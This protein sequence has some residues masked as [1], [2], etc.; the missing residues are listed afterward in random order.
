M[1]QATVTITTTARDAPAR[2]AADEL[3]ARLHLPRVE[4]GAAGDA[5]LALVW[6]GERL[7]L[8]EQAE[9]DRKGM[10]VDFTTL[11]VRRGSRNL[12][13]KQPL[14]RAI[15]R[16][17]RT[18]ADA[19][20]GLGHD[21]VLLACLGY[22]VIAIERSPVVAALLEDG[23]R[24]AANDQTLRRAIGGRIRLVVGDARQVL[25]TL[26]PPPDAVFIDPMFP[27]KRKATAL[28][29]KPIRLVR[30]LVG[31]D[32]DASELVSIARRVAGRVIV[33][34]P[35]YVQPL[36]GPPEVSFG[37]KLARYD[38]Y[39]GQRTPVPPEKASIA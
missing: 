32:P 9:I 14:A 27:P 19:T 10:F 21:A 8:R 4:A 25:E 33:K 7:E 13:R 17:V 12:S 2:A 6:T 15:G 24:R 31:E 37:G 22:E 16:R 36:A 38:V 1:S 11:D 18:V 39:G 28:A 20:A 30:R 5:D 35:T 26:D 29:R 34:R 23:L 3:A